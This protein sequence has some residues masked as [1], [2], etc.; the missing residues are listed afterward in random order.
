[1]EP[2]WGCV[3]VIPAYLMALVVV[4]PILIVRRFGVG[5][6]VLRTTGSPELLHYAGLLLG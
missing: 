5:A 2:R 1:M 6:A 4:L 3:L